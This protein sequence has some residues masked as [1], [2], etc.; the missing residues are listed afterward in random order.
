MAT[1]TVEEFKR[2]ASKQYTGARMVLNGHKYIRTFCQYA[3][4]VDLATGVSET[5]DQ[6]ADYFL[7]QSR[8]ID[9]DSVMVDCVIK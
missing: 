6:L 1:M 3:I 8:G 4:W 7:R 5:T 9:N 2:L